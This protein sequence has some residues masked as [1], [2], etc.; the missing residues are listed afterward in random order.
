VAFLLLIVARTNCAGQQSIPDLSEASLEQLGDTKVYSA[1]KHLQTARDAPSSVTVITA[2]EIQEYGYRTLADILR[3][4]RGFFVTYDRNYSS[5]GAR[6]FARPGDYNT[7][8][9]LLVDGHRLNDNIYDEAMIGTEFPVDIDLIQRVEIIRGPTSSLYGSNALFAVINIITK[10]GQDL[11]G[12]ELSSEA[13]SFNTYAGRISYGGKLQQLEFLISGT[14]YGSRGHNRLFF[15]EF[16]AATTNYGVASHADDDQVGSA[17]ATVSFRDFTLQGVYGTREKGIPTAAFGTMFNNAGTR[18]T[19]SHGYLD[20]HYEHTFAKSWGVLART[21]YDSYTYHGTYIYASPLDPAQIVPNLDFADGKWWGTELQL[22]KTVLSRNRITVGTEY[23]DNIRQNQT[24]YD[25]NPYSLLV[26]DRRNSFVAGAYLQDELTVTK[27]LTLNGGVRYDYYSTVQA[28]TDPRAALIYRPWNQTALKFIYGVAFRA[29]NA[30]ESYYN[31]VP[32]L[33][34]PVL[35]SEKIHGAEFVWEQGISSRFWLTT[36][37]FYN[38]INNLITQDPESLLFHNLQNVKS[39]GL[40]LEVK[41]QLSSGLEGVASYSFQQTKDR[42]TSQFLSD[43]PRNLATLNLKQSLFGRRMMVSLDAQYRSQI[44]SL[45]GGSVSPF[46]IVNF[47]ILGRRIG[48]HVDISAS[49]YNLLDKQYFDPPSSANP[50]QSIG[51]DGRSV[52]IKM[53][54]H[55][56]ER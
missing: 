12:L 28:S 22:T 38:T 40:E 49:V 41:S 55:L 11:K 5:L 35:R 48:R 47:T 45:A 37:Y 15:P 52:R 31:L 10:R 30:Y 56:G 2:A 36:S 53:T 25:L 50:Q 32:S 3:T 21:F 8:I 54:W 26:D 19:D 29:P 4:V 16:N 42:V 20:L 7:R 23:R 43:S 18:T 39:T 9:L 13:A 24:N 1:S 6:G 17:L 34:A 46:S 14:F 44:Q 51:Q 33:P 27:Y